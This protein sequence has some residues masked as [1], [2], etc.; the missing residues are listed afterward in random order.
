M[1][2]ANRRRLSFVESDLK[3]DSAF[4]WM[5]DIPDADVRIRRLQAQ[6]ARDDDDE[7]GAADHGGPADLRCALRARTRASPLSQPKASIAA[8]SAEL[9]SKVEAMEADNVPRKCVVR[10]PKRRPKS[11]FARRGRTSVIV[12]VRSGAVASFRLGPLDTVGVLRNC[13]QKRWGF[14]PECQ[15]LSLNGRALRSEDDSATVADLKASL[16]MVNNSV[17]MCT[18]L[19]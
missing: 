18:P 5:L 16:G 12:R 15:E 1:S 3:P 11:A 6:A 2:A 4:G 19:I 9:R 17:I 14:P 7:T 10:V 13:V 8:L